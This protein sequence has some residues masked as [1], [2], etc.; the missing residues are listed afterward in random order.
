MKKVQHVLDEIGVFGHWVE[1]GVCVV[2]EFL[3]R[4]KLFNTAFVHDH[5][6]VVVHD[7][8]KSMSDREDGAAFELLTNGRLNEVISLEVDGGGGLVQDEHFSLP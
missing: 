1:N 5:N 3:R 7:G 6:A 4:I 2:D 8:I